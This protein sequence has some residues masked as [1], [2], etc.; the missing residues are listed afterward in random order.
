MGGFNPEIVGAEKQEIR[1]HQIAKTVKAPEKVT[2]RITM[3]AKWK[4]GTYRNV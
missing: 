3:N 2:R 1:K 4:H